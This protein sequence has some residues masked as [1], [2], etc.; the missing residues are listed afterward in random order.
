MSFG[1]FS[2]G[3]V[4]L[5]CMHAQLLLTPS[6]PDQDFLSALLFFF[7]GEGLSVCAEPP[8]HWS[9]SESEWSD[10]QE[11]RVQEVE[12]EVLDREEANLF[13]GFNRKRISFSMLRTAVFRAR[14]ES[15]TQFSKSGFSCIAID[16][17]ME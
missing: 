12:E 17:K 13:F 16:N 7:R 9:P 14:E 5:V 4:A 15:L 11:V 8:S 1:V 6:S 10:Q 2:D 3:V